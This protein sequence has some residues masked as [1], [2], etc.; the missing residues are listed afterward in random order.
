MSYGNNRGGGYQQRGGGGGYGGNRQGGGY[1]RNA[2]GNGGGGRPA[3]KDM[4]GSLRPNPNKASP[5]HPD[6]KG[7]I[8]IG[9]RKYWLSG[10]E[11][12]SPDGGYTKLSATP[13]DEDASRP[14][15]APTRGAPQQQQQNDLDDEVPF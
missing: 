14:Q 5:A 4:T 8:V 11:N 12:E 1:N 13:A 7:S 2:G 10:W 15:A 9:G 6:V 3:A